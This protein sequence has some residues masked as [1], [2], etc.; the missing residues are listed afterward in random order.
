MDDQGVCMPA[1]EKIEFESLED[2]ETIRRYLH[3]LE[4]GFSKGTI[5]LTSEGKSLILEPNGF[6]SF[7]LTAKRKSG[8]TK[9]N[10]KL[11]WKDRDE[12]IK[13]SSIHIE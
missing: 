6:L 10:I 5:S 1:E 11:S 13:K 12:S 7:H 2:C 3:A 9:I 4:Q 8:E